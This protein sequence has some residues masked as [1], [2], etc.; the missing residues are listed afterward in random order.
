[1]GLRD[2]WP[3]LVYATLAVHIRAEC[4]GKRVAID[5]SIY[6]MH[7]VKRHHFKIATTGD[8]TDV[9]EDVMNMLC[10]L[11]MLGVSPIAVFDG[12]PLPAKAATQADRR[13]KAA[14][15]QSRVDAALRKQET[16][17]DADTKLAA[18]FSKAFKL[19]L[20]QKMRQAGV[21]YVVSPYEADAQ[22]AHMARTRLCE[23]IMTNDC[24]LIASMPD[25]STYGVL[26]NY[27]QRRHTA[28]L[29][30][31]AS[32]KSKA[33]GKASP[34]HK[35]LVKWGTGLI[36]YLAAAGGCDYGAIQGLGMTGAVTAMAKLTKSGSKSLAERVTT[37][38]TLLSAQQRGNKTQASDI[39]EHIKKIVAVYDNQVVYDMRECC[40]VYSSGA[41]SA[42]AHVGFPTA[43][44]TTVMDDEMATATAAS[45]GYFTSHSTQTDD[46]C[47]ISQH[48]DE[49]TSAPSHLLAYMVTG[50]NIAQSR[51]TEVMIAKG[52][53]DGAPT[54]AELRYFLRTRG[55][56]ELR[57][58]GNQPLSWMDLAEAVRLK[59]EFEAG[60]QPGACDCAAGTCECENAPRLYVRDPT[61][62]CMLQHWIEMGR[63]D[64]ESF[65]QFDAGKFQVTDDAGWQTGIT[66]IGSTAP[67][68]SEAVLRAH[69][70][71]RM[72][73]T[74]GEPRVLKRGYARLESLTSVDFKYHPAPMAAT[75]IVA[76]TMRCPASFT[77]RFYDVTVFARFDEDANS[78]VKP[79]TEIVHAVCKPV[80]K[81]GGGARGAG[82]IDDP[83]T[84][85]GWCKASGTSHAGVGGAVFASAL[86]THVSCLLQLVL[87][88]PRPAGCGAAEA[89]TSQLCK[90]SRP[91]GGNALPKHTEIREFQFRKMDRLR[92]GRRR[93]SAAAD[94]SLRPL[95]VPIPRRVR[96]HNTAGGKSKAL[97]DNM[98]DACSASFLGNSKKRKRS[99][100]GGGGGN[101]DG[102]SA[103]TAAARAAAARFV[104]TDVLVHPPAVRHARMDNSAGVGRVLGVDASGEKV[105]VQ[106]PG[107]RKCSVLP[108]RLEPQ[109]CTCRAKRGKGGAAAC[110]CGCGV[111]A[112]GAGFSPHAANSVDRKALLRALGASDEKKLE[113]KTA[114][115]A[116]VHFTPTEVVS[117][118]TAGGELLRKQLAPG[119]LPNRRTGDEAAGLLDAVEDEELRSKLAKHI[120]QLVQQGEQSQHQHAMALA[121][122]GSQ[123][124]GLLSHITL[125]G[126]QFAHKIREYTGFY[127]TGALDAFLELMDGGEG[128][129]A[130]INPHDAGEE[131]EL[132]A[133]MVTSRHKGTN[134]G[135]YVV[136]VAAPDQSTRSAAASSSSDRSHGIPEDEV[137]L[138]IGVS[139]DGSRLDV[140]RPCGNVVNGVGTDA[141]EPTDMPVYE[142]DD[143]D[144]ETERGRERAMDWRT[145]LCFVLF[146][147][148]VGMDLS[149]A[150]ALWGVSHSTACR[151]YVVYLL[152]LK[153]RLLALFPPL[154]PDQLVACCPKRISDHFPGRKIQSIIDAHEQQ[155]EEPSD[156][157]CR[158]SVYSQYKS[159]CTVKYMGSIAP[160]GACTE[161]SEGRGGACDDVTLVIVSRMLERVY[162]GF[163]SLADKG[164]MMHREYMA[165]MHELLTPP[166]KRHKADT[167]N[168]DEMSTTHSIG[169]PRSHVERTFKRGQEWK[170]LHKT[171]KLTSVDLAGTVFAVAMRM[172]NFDKP[173]I[174]EGDGPLK[175]LAELTW[176]RR[177][178]AE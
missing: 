64:L 100:G 17:K 82:D 74:Q 145:A 54:V 136:P 110:V 174:R 10:G 45:L 152:A 151:Y 18:T 123:C 168:L 99:D 164:F 3:Y 6:V 8:F 75:D 112:K 171:L 46:L 108:Q 7:F 37:M 49:N 30:T 125:K 153:H 143:S 73:T 89:V 22:L 41:A 113:S 59:L 42:P 162:P 91:G 71:P 62:K 12:K 173:M 32:L 13:Q 47:A 77:A 104:G 111:D 105:Q 154:T 90:W 141:F 31:A 107:Q 81:S 150:D 69:F 116:S 159:C 147:T 38:A 129:M 29:Y 155:M 158:R 25:D 5:M 51:V 117:T 177:G 24:D 165:V 56:D 163:S 36:P 106:V 140:K 127:S 149:D 26:R 115:I 70:K 11:R 57:G 133:E 135:S 97:W 68:L 61:G 98:M 160:S 137:V 50:A 19:Q 80:M 124:S 176:G 178:D 109:L 166:K 21:M 34:M 48:I 138:V 114:R 39:E 15:A 131:M 101:G 86:C 20:I 55:Y 122:V 172:I 142:D 4:S 170:A 167:F 128:L 27:D 102:K 52:P 66:A 58:P 95:R 92:E 1:M 43:G 40:D 76:F 14:D 79:I 84:A 134:A 120:A 2:F 88:L 132:A 87:N 85:V 72:D 156:L 96:H 16:P 148:R 118:Y 126:Q 161:T 78:S 9:L 157:T 53:G 119:A 63:A 103:A 35:M 94:T 65:P 146:V 60:Q 23:Y 83:G 121:S 28:D 175:S 130:S 169:G 33:E 44:N 144:T 93:A 139:K 67:S